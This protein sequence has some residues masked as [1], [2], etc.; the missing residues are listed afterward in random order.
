M[1]FM[2]R[3]INSPT[4]GTLNASTGRFVKRDLWLPNEYADDQERRR[5]GRLIHLAICNRDNWFAVRDDIERE[6]PDWPIRIITPLS[7][8]MGMRISGYTVSIH[9]NTAVLSNTEY[10]RF[11]AW[12]DVGVRCRIEPPT[13][14]TVEP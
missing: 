11:L 2:E 8:V 12:L 6:Q 1:R 14:A 9:C 13:D 5:A 7:K 4:A 10:T 3:S